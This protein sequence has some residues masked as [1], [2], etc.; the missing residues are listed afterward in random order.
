MYSLCPQC[1]C[2]DHFRV[3]NYWLPLDRIQSTL[4]GETIF[5]CDFNIRALNEP[6]M[7]LQG[8][9]TS[10]IMGGGGSAFHPHSPPHTT[11]MHDTW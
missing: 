9:A 1:S 7:L 5:H 6:N 2:F 8:R 3:N 11:P 4:A 10:R